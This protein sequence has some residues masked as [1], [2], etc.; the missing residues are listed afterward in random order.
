M[1]L[2]IQRVSEASVISNGVK[3][4][5]IGKGLLVL[6]GVTHNDTEED[7]E[8]LVKKVTNLRIFGDEK[9]LMN[10]SIGDVGGSFVVVSQFTLFASTKKGNRPS[11]LDAAKR[12]IAIPLYEK[13]VNS[14]RNH[15]QLDVQEG[16]FG[17]DMKVKLVNDGP[18]T[19]IIDSKKRT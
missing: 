5:D 13:F 2:V 19:I 1:R 17:A 9:G 15:S 4:A 16:L 3:T 7:I 10:L 11:F 12:D 8:W 6:H 14:L 18:E